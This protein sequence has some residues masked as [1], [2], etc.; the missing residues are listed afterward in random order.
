[1]SARQTVLTRNRRGHGEGITGKERRRLAVLVCSIGLTAYTTRKLFRKDGLPKR[2]FEAE[3]SEL[4][5]C[6]LPVQLKLR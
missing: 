4:C 5:G 2:V 3:K 1:V 6:G